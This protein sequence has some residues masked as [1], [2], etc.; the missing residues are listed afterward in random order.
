MDMPSNIRGGGGWEVT[1]WKK[2]KKQ[3]QKKD[4]K[5]GNTCCLGA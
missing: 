1:L 4:G 2:K 3:L 5:N